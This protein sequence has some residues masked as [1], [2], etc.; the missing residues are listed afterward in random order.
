MDNFWNK[1]DR[2]DNVVPFTPRPTIDETIHVRAVV[3]RST[4]SVLER[5]LTIKGLNQN[6]SVECRNAYLHP[7]KIEIHSFDKKLKI[8]YRHQQ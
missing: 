7:L 2:P 1:I 5:M 8:L 6:T 3:E 4:K